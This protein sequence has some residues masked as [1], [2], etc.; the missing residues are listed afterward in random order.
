MKSL[1]LYDK[2]DLR[3]EKAPPPS[4]IK[5][6]DVIIEVKAAGICGSDISRYKKLGPYVPGMIWGHEFS[7]VVAEI[8]S[9]V[10]HVSIGDN[11]VGCPA[12]YCGV[13]E[14]CQ[15]GEPARCKTLEVMGAKQPG[16]FASYTKLPEENVIPIPDNVDFD[17]AALVEPSAV[18]LHGVYKTSMKP[19]DAVAVL[20][21]GNIGLLTIQWAKLFGADTVYAIDI[22]E[23]KLELA[24]AVGADVLVNP[25]QSSIYEQL[26][27]VTDNKGVDIAIEA[28]GTPL[29]S[30]HIFSLAK[31]GGEVVF[32]GIPYADIE[33]ERF[34]FEKIVRNEL[35]VYGAWN[36]I[37]APFPGKEWTATL[38]KL[39]TG[40][41]DA[42]SII[43]HRL[44]LEEGPSTFEAIIENQD[45][46]S[47]VLLY[48]H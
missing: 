14:S 13:C 27:E 23:Q 19:G 18:A 40:E 1:K 29:T 3:F 30:A 45:F 32:M 12:L 43:S 6:N 47:K 25:A 5:P 2:R 37:S 38:T 46:F 10:T 21:C 8:G 4:I 42:K 44:S 41:L 26:M 31:K 48:P 17:S 28:A 24:K 36:A 16:A 22:D 33:I 35:G 34:Y 15:S 11:V 39:S 7:G 20:G 9:D